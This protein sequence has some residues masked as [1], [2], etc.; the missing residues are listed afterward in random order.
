MVNLNA[1]YNPCQYPTK[2]MP[3]GERGG[4]YSSALP[5]IKLLISEIAASDNVNAKLRTFSNV[6]TF[7]L[8]PGIIAIPCWVA[9]RY[10]TC[11]ADTLWASANH[12]KIFE[13]TTTVQRFLRP[14]LEY[15]WYAMS[16]FSHRAR[17][18]LSWCHGYILFWITEGRIRI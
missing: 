11:A 18:S 13:F 6:L 5:P 4:S 16:S 10:A 9:Q 2:P 7:R 8:L 14:R 1:Q 3:C 17:T 12:P 15:A